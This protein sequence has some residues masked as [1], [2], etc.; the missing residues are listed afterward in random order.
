MRNEPNPGGAGRDGAPEA[1]DAGQSCKTTS[2][3]SPPL[4]D[5][6]AA[7]YAQIGQF[8]RAIRTTEQAIEIVRRNPKASTETLE[9][10]LRLYRAGRPYREAQPQ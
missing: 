3:K 5:S 8:D 1:W 9:S 7:A 4:L 2:H 6:L 10:R